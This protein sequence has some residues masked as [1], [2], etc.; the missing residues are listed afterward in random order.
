VTTTQPRPRPAGTSLWQRTNAEQLPGAVALRYTTLVR[1]RTR[2][3]DT[4]RLASA[5]HAVIGL[6]TADARGR[7]QACSAG[8]LLVDWPC[9]TRQALD[10][11]L[12][13]GWPIPTD[14]TEPPDEPTPHEGFA[15]A[16]L[17][18]HDILPAAG[19]H[20]AT[21]RTC[22]T[23]PG[24]CPVWALADGFL[25]ITWHDHPTDPGRPARTA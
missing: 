24:D 10:D 11:G 5:L 1:F 21:C 4:A 8:P 19:G 3:E 18:I 6:H 15:L 16:I 12:S 2:Q 14:T 23:P 13:H 22:R 17:A 25:G 20:P 7:C 9:R